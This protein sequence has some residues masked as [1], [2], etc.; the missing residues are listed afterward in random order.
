V[1]THS[2]AASAPMPSVR[3]RTAWVAASPRSSTTSVAPNSRAGFWGSG[4][5]LRAMIRSAPRRA[6]RQGSRIAP[7]PRRRFRVRWAAH[8]FKFHRTGAKRLN[9]PV[10]GDL[11]LAYEALELPGDS[12]QRILAYT[13][14]PATPTQ[15]ALDL[16]ASWAFT[17]NSSF[18]S[19]DKR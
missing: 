1:P 11:I 2:R 9:H 18:D 12:G 14:A 6:E 4:C 13:A 3:S 8:N 16:L 19:V 7:S 17:P 15:D 10:V 5:R